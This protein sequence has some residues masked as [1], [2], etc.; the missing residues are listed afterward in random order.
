MQGGVS[1]TWGNGACASRLQ[2]PGLLDP[3]TAGGIGTGSTAAAGALL[4]SE[5][6]KGRITMF[7]WCKL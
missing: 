7:S 4:L 3:I 6:L 1:E 2:L 5:Q